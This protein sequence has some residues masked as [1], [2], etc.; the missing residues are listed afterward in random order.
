[1][2]SSV[3]A[4]RR[5]S[6]V[7]LNLTLGV[8]GTATENMGNRYFLDLPIYRIAEDRYFR[9]RETFIEKG[10]YS[11]NS[12]KLHSGLQSIYEANPQFADAARDRLATSYG[13]IWRFNEIVGYVRLYFLGTQI[14][15]E[16]Y[17]VRRNRLVR[18]R[19][20]T[21]EFI[22]WKLATE[23]NVP[24]PITDEGIYRAVLEYVERCRAEFPRRH[25]DSEPLVVLGEHLRWRELLLEK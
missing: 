14:R 13:G 7:P 16:H 23:V 25:I 19:T 20:K 3:R 18:T 5:K 4:G 11:V 10:L 15:G 1:M 21:F 9:E 17:G 8:I 22:H 2:K 6:A 24:N 12:E